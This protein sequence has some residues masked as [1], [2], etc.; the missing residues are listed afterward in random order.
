MP[1]LRYS[2]RSSCSW[3]NTVLEPEPQ[4]MN[5]GEKDRASVHLMVSVQ[6]PTVAVAT[7]LSSSQILHP[8]M[9]AGG[10]GRCE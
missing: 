6:G 7:P 5:V 1:T 10:G 2:R 3:E 9:K 8:T 4:A